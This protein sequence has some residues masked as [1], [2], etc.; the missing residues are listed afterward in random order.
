MITIT[1]PSTYLSA[2]S[3]EI[4]VLPEKRCE[5]PCATIDIHFIALYSSLE[6]TQFQG[7]NIL[8]PKALMKADLL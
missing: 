8:F 3:F 5:K 7:S 1:L 6:M 2:S 4:P